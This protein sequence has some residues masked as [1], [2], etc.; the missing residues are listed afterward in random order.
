MTREAS[1]SRGKVSGEAIKFLL[2][3]I[4]LLPDVGVSKLLIQLFG[5]TDSLFPT[6][7]SFCRARAFASRF[8]RELV[9]VQVSA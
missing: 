5:V 9:F 4:I 1:L 2:V 3:I 7:L 6:S 8:P